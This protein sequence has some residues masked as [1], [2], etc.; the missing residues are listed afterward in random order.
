MPGSSPGSAAGPQPLSS[1]A[2]NWVYY[3]LAFS[4]VLIVV[5][6]FYMNHELTQVYVAQIDFVRATTDRTGR[7]LEL[8]QASGDVE[9]AGSE[10]LSE[11]DV[12]AAPEKLHAASL[13]FKDRLDSFRKDLQVIPDKNETAPWLR[14]L[15]Q[16]EN[17]DAELEADAEQVFLFQKQEK[18]DRAAQNL[19]KVHEKEDEIVGRLT[20]LRALMLQAQT[21]QLDKN[22]VAAASRRK[23]LDLAALFTVFLMFGITAY[24]VTLSR[25]VEAA[26]QQREQYEHALRKANE[27]LDRRVQERTAELTQAN[28][29]LHEEIAE[30]K[31]AE[32][33]LGEAQERFKGIY[34]SS[35][36]GIAYA[37]LDGHFIDVNNAFTQLTGYSKEEL[38]AMRY[39]DLVPEKFHAADEKIVSDMIKTGAPVEQ[40]REYKTK[41]GSTVPVSLTAFVVRGDDGQ[42][43]GLATIVKDITERKWAEGELTHSLSILRSTLESTG[44][45]ILV[46]D[47]EGK[48]V[49]ANRKYAQIWG[50]PEAAVSSPGALRALTFDLN[51]LKDPAGFHSKLQDLNAKP[52]A[53]STGFI[54]FIDG[55][56]VEHNSLPHQIGGKSVGRVWSFR[57]V[58]ERFRIEEKLRQSEEQFRLITENVADLIAVLDLEGRRVYN[59]P[60]YKGMLGDPE[61]LRGTLSFSE[62]HPDDR[63]RIKKIFEETIRT[64]VGQR[65]EY[66]FLLKNGSIR[67]MESQ[68][69]VIRDRNGDPEKVVVVSRD[70]TRRKRAEDTLRE[71]EGRFRLVVQATNDAVWDWDLLT[72]LFWWNEGV[73]TLFG[74]NREELGPDASWWTEHIHPEDQERVISGVYEQIDGG[75]KAWTDEYRFR[76][77]DGS[78]AYIL[79]R[80]YVIHEDGGKPVRMIGAMMDVTARKTAEKEIKDLNEGLELRVEERT[81][82]LAAV[83]ET[84]EQRNREVERMTMLKSQ[85]LASMSHELRTPLNAIIGFADLIQDGT[86]GAI[87]EK[88]KSFVKHIQQAGRHLLDLINDILDL[89][90]IEAGQLTIQPENFAP[91]GALPEVLSVIKPLAMKKH[92][93][94]QYEV[95]SELTV[96]ADR[97]RFKQII[98][99]LLSNAVKFTP[100]GGKIKVE[101]ST[102]PGFVCI[103]VTDTGI[104]IKPEDHDVIFEE[105]RQVGHTTRGVTEG[106]GLGLAICKRLVEQ[107]EGKIWIESE[108][109]KGSK[110]SFTLPEGRTLSVTQ[111]PAEGAPARPVREKPLILVVDNDPASRELLVS[112]LTGEI[113]QTESSSAGEEGLSK[114]RQ[115]QPDVVTLDIL[116]QDKSSWATFSDLKTNPTTAHIPII[117]ISAADDKNVGYTQGAAERL[118]KP[119]SREILMNAL[120]KHLP[121]AKT[122]GPAVLVVEN[123]PEAL[124]AITK[125]LETGGYSALVA[126]NGKEAQDILWLV[127]V[128]AA[129][130]NL[131]MPE[132]DGFELFR[133]VKQNPRLRDIPVLVFVGNEITASESDF[134]KREARARLTK[135]GAWK[136]NLIKHLDEILHRQVVPS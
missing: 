37:S 85:F 82:Q 100:E 127:R 58:T 51:Q 23:F 44:D 18:H 105:F 126:R 59:S 17:A 77:K 16:I 123:N 112:Y 128:D 35:K 13:I 9:D 130:L 10:V 122:S 39:R 94:I 43:A 46:V 107:Q 22:L 55:R 34:E 121:T 68:G 132:M 111:A 41:D 11:E 64:G 1:P 33:A 56:I 114:A 90:K 91:G 83:N 103:S 72:N 57:D 97:V 129:L 98:Y 62:I 92:I 96:F 124:R 131:S 115:L 63:E 67:Y 84:L 88:Q 76:R 93:E 52:E 113:F 26:G 32:G 14:D 24:G 8:R 95:G 109:G 36:D 86:S 117:V 12:A 81:A 135:E 133:R 29:T 99:N 106:T 25:R 45:G 134:L 7:L 30:R 15:D 60:S 87:N 42:T 49:S 104:G 61:K 28:Q 54:E 71:S 6:S 136:D 31:R 19:K 101:S 120:I 78:Y 73:T 4:V 116:S 110:F 74:Y 21:D 53:E 79:D 2:W 118:G 48:I 66:R 69:S 75:G 108:I 80:A 40:E 50:I 65:S 27:E 38:S 119:V 89:S 20:H 102:P 3:P 5:I 70:V 47:S 125:A